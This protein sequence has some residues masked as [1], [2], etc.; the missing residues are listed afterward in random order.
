MTHIWP[1]NSSF[2]GSSQRPHNPYST[3]AFLAYRAHNPFP[4]SYN[5]L[6]VFNITLASSIVAGARS[7]Y[8]SVVFSSHATTEHNL[9]AGVCVADVDEET[10]SVEAFGMQFSK[11]DS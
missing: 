7:K 9:V 4:F 6:A 3:E 5:S 10:W 1:C 11:G 2:E 8:N